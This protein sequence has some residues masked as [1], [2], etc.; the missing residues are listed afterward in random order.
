MFKTNLLLLVKKQPET[1]E[2]LIPE[3]RV[4]L[5]TILEDKDSVSFQNKEDESLLQIIKDF[6][7]LSSGLLT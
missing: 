3:Q 2:C 7:C 4:D 6:S 5:L 1:I